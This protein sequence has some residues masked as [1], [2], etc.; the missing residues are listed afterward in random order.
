MS[1]EQGWAYLLFDAFCRALQAAYALFVDIKDG[2]IRSFYE[3]YGF[4]LFIL[5][6]D[7]EAGR[8]AMRGAVA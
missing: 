2:G 7:P 1:E 8:R 3:Y 6:R 4:R 5:L